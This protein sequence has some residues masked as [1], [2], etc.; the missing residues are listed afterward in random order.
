MRYEVT[1]PVLVKLA[2]AILENK[3]LHS[4]GPNTQIWYRHDGE[5]VTET[6]VVSALHELPRPENNDGPAWLCAGRLKEILSRGMNLEV[7]Q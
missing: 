6:K 5:T 1:D 3:N 4:P 7:D 2:W